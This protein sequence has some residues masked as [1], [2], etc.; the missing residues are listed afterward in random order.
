MTKHRLNLLSSCQP[1][2]F[3]T[4]YTPYLN[5]L[6]IVQEL[7]LRQTH[8]RLETAERQPVAGERGA[9]AQLQAFWNKREGLVGVEALSRYLLKWQ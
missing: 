3:I 8:V 9:R 1:I 6:M 5:I 2:N 7:G 4:I